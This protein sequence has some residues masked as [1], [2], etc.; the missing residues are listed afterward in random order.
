MATQQPGAPPGLPALTSLPRL[1]D[2]PVSDQGYDQGR[3]REAEARGARLLEQSRHQATELT[4]AARAE[5]EQ[6]LEWARAQA[7]TIIHRAQQGAEQ[8]LT[9]AGLASEDVKPV[10]DAIINSAEAA[11]AAS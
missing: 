7:L 2:L 10:V 9:A 8:L 6:T 11:A 4:N 5:V 3:V 1:E